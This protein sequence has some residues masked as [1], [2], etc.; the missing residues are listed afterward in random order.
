MY[1]YGAGGLVY[2][3]REI[4]DA[5]LGPTSTMNLAAAKMPC[6]MLYHPDRRQ[7]WVWWAVA[8][9]DDPSVLYVLDV[10]SGGWSQFTGNVTGARCAV[11]FADSLGATMGYRLKPY[12]NT[13]GSASVMK[14][15]DTSATTDLGSGNFQAT[16][17]TRPIQPGGAGYNGQMGD[18]VLLA[19]VATG[20]TLTATVTPD[21]AASA[22]KTGTALLTAAGSETR[23]SKRMAGTD[24]ESAQFLQITIGDAAASTSV[25]SF[26]RLVAAVSR[27]EAIA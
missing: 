23:V 20:V 5:V 24:L 13:N 2:I 26:D 7:L 15:D 27:Q 25:W 11:M 8:S 16:L 12:V 6:H 14:A 22:T 4:E 19:P 9:G 3:G 21:F 1:R 17:T 10:Q 18:L